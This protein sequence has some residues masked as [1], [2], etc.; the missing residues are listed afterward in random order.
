M[1][2]ISRS[3]MMAATGQPAWL[4]TASASLAEA[5][6][7]TS[8]SGPLVSAISR[9]TTVCGESS[10]I[11]TVRGGG[12]FESGLASIVPH[13]PSLLVLTSSGQESV[14]H[15]M[16]C[17]EMLRDVSVRLELLAKLNNVGVD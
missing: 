15:A 2:G 13:I 17:E 1:R 9:F 6:I 16:N 4:R 14:T 8:N 5:T 3:V 10:T 12:M 7:C 11:R